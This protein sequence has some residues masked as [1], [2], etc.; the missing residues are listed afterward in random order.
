MGLANSQELINLGLCT[1]LP[2]QVCLSINNKETMQP[3]SILSHMHMKKV[4]VQCNHCI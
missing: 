2:G 4:F 3:P 1:D